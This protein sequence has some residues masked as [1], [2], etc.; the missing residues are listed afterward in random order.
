M[1]SVNGGRGQ[2]NDNLGLIEL[3]LY[4]ESEAGLT[5]AARCEQRHLPGL[6]YLQDLAPKGT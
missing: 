4:L 3:L 6:I 1:S 2:L 5:A